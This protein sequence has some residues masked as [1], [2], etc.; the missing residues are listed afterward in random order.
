MT[1]ARISFEFRHQAFTDALAR[2]DISDPGRRRRLLRGIGNGLRETARHRFRTGTDPQGRAWAPL[3]PG[4]AA[5]RKSGPILVQMGD[6]GGLMGTMIMQTGPNQVVV[7]SNKKY[8]AIH[9]FGG[10][11][12][13]KNGRALVFRIG[14]HVVHAR[15]VTIPARPYLGFGPADEEAVLDAI[16]VLLPGGRP[17]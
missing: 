17:A 9:Q 6:N 3:N 16:D 12:L 14:G 4:Y 11:I 13:P 1:G 2:L 15:H 7:G 5:V 8:A 10:V